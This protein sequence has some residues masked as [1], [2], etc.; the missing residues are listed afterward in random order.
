MTAVGG[1][2]VDPLSRYGSKTQFLWRYSDVGFDLLF[3]DTGLLDSTGLNVDVEGLNWAPFGG[4]VVVDSFPNFEIRLSHGAWLPDE[5]PNI[6]LQP[7]FPLSGVVQI[8][9]NQPT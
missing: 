2:V 6:V 8:F 5:L 3:P 4:Q 9:E 7:V 1:G